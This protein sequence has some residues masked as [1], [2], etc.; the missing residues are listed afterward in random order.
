[1]STGRITELRLTAFKSYADVT[2]PLERLTLFIGRN[3]SGKSN[4]LDALEVLSRLARGDEVRDALEGNRRDAGPVRGGLDGCAPHGSD[5]FEIGVTLEAD[6]SRSIT[7]DL[8]VQVR[9]Q[10]QIVWERLCAYVGKSR[11]VTLLESQELG[12]HRADLD[13]FVYNGSR[14]RNPKLTFRSSHLLTAQLPLRVAGKTAGERELIDVA[15]AALAVLGGVFH[16]DP[17]PHL[18]RQYV[19]EQ[20]VVLRR[21]AENISAAVARLKHDDREKFARLVDVVGA[22]PEYDV[23]TL[24]IGRSGFGDVMLAIKERK[25]RS[26]VPVPARQMSDGMLRML[27]IA[28]ALLT[29]GGGLAINATTSGRAAALMLVIEELENG[30]HPSQAAQLL[31]LVKQASAEQGFQ[32][33]LTTH[34]PA[35]LNALP[36]EDHRGV[37]VVERDRSSGTSTARRLV[38]LP[39]Y[40]RLMAGS[41]LGD[42]AAAGRLAVAAHEGPAMSDA[43]LDRL[44]GIA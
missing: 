40:A 5:T 13:A 27:A 20:D 2:V 32:V 22:L 36:G 18:M 25:G 12:R 33:V 37:I 31:Q 7:L 44:L 28:T 10:V 42:A 9:P 41:R 29:G 8:R 30:L 24:D 34:S 14:G 6:V 43:Q 1:M 17:V 16:L 3:G 4:A 11:W 39:G 38:D 23:R 15:E 21:T 26:I 35:L 19:A